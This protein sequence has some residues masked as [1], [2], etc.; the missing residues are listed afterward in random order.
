MRN[1]LIFGCGSIG[2]HMSN[3]CVTLGWKVFITD[4]N[5]NALI[6]MKKLIY[7]LRYKKWSNK[8]TQ[9]SYKNV[10]SSKQKF[11]LII[12]GT[13]PSTHYQILKNCEKNF[14]FKKILIEKPISNFE[15]NKIYNLSKNKKKWIFCGYNHS[16]NPSM[17][18][19][20]KKLK[21]IISKVKAV[22]INWKEGWEGIL[23]AHPWLKNEFSS[24]LGNYKK[25]GGSIQ[26]HSHGIHALV[27][28][29]NFFKIKKFNFSKKVVFFKKNN[30]KNIKYDYYA[31]F[32]AEIKKILFKYETDL[33]TY[34]PEKNIYIKLDSGYLKWICNYKNN[35]DAVIF[36]NKT[37]YIVKFFKKKRSTE[38]INELNYVDNI[39]SLKQYK[40]SKINLEKAL[41]TFK[42][43]QELLLK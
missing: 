22:N 20:F 4:N 17:S 23:G 38:F 42:I 9:V 26:E 37:Q 40:N 29:L 14:I 1:I 24:Y 27:C 16:V 39:S 19:F 41:K 5:P 10:F 33:I 43:I 36:K 3:A 25:G 32:F 13:P 30:K 11:D 18:Y 7:P 35:R 6:R 15:D 28:I 31:G 8:I 34:P 12:I 2:N 21:T